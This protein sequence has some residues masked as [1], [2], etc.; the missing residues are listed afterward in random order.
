VAAD[1]DEPLSISGFNDLVY[2]NQIWYHLRAF[3]VLGVSSFEQGTYIFFPVPCLLQLIPL[4]VFLRV[5]SIFNFEPCRPGPLVVT[6]SLYFG[7]CD[8]DDFSYFR[9]VT[10]W[11]VCRNLRCSRQISLV[12][13]GCS[14]PIIKSFTMRASS[15][16]G[17][18]EMLLEFVQEVAEGSVSELRSSDFSDSKH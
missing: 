5:M 17:D 1:F 6:K 13:L 2:V 14:S 18:M 3:Q 4:K 16:T 7:T 10:F 15:S 8:L 9:N 11:T 12:D